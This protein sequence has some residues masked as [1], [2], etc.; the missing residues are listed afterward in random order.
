MIDPQDHFDTLAQLLW[1]GTPLSKV[2]L[3]VLIFGAQAK[4]VFANAS[5]TEAIG[6]ALEECY[7]LQGFDISP[8]LNS[9]N[10]EAIL[11]AEDDFSIHFRRKDWKLLSIRANCFQSIYQGN[12]LRVLIW[13]VLPQEAIGPGQ[14]KKYHYDLSNPDKLARLSHF[15]IQRASDAIFWI[16]AT[17][18]ITHVNEEACHRLGYTRGELT[19]M[20]IHE[21]N[22][23]LQPAGLTR[24]FEKLRKQGSLVIES[25]H[26]TKAGKA[27]P[28]E[29]TSNYIF[30][31][32]VEYT[33]SI[34]RDI[35]E[36][37]RKEAALRGALTEIQ[38]LRGR[39]EAENNY[40][41]E[42][43]NHDL[44]FGEI[45]SQSKRMRRVL[46]EVEQVANT[47]ST[48]LIL[49]ESGTGKELIARVL[50][51]MS[52]RSERPMIK[53]NCAALPANLIES[54]LFG[55]EKGAFT[56]AFSRKIGRFEL[57]DKSTIFLD[58]IGEMPLELQSKLLRVLQEGEFERLGAETTIKVDVRILAA[59]NRDLEKEVEQGEFREDLYYRLNVFPIQCPPLR[60]RKEDIPLLVS[61]FCKKLENKIG[62][63]ITNIPKKLLEQ[64]SEYYFPGNIREL[65]NIIERAVIL[66][67]DGKLSLGNW[68]PK[69][70]LQANKESLETLEELNRMH[71]IKA[72]KMTEW[73][74]SGAKGAAKLLGLKPTTLESR[75]KKMQISRSNEVG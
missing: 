66:S 9:R 21:V 51:K 31:E 13:E 3:P 17:G 24:A 22:K 65:E 34:V 7:A 47:S 55:H 23:V 16:T 71:I 60:D 10:W 18:E 12:L 52:P 75:M 8:D 64:L 59:T 63:K 62:K 28:V 2:K 32:G 19:S 4:V 46:R 11:D 39:L 54:E 40:L 35:T 67:R 45:I 48:V 15:T 37:N 33:C 42:E 5:A 72:L 44:L 73:R 14:Y 29:I 36:R 69:K 26:Y 70:R 6:Y 50:H 1:N 58:E 41:Q 61:H 20:S 43:I 30:F 57:A 74:I 38:E 25:K 27:I 68:L 56:G 49:G 53:V